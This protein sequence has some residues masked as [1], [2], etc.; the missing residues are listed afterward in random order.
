[1][2]IKA[3]VSKAE[4]KQAY[5]KAAKKH[6]PDTITGSDEMFKKLSEAYT[7]LKALPVNF[8]ENP[9]DPVFNWKN[10]QNPGFVRPSKKDPDFSKSYS[11]SDSGSVPQ[12]MYFFEGFVYALGVFLIASVGYLQLT[13]DS[14]LKEFFEARRQLSVAVE[15]KSLAAADYRMGRLIKY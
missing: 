6:H 14:S 1:M 3:G 15:E 4:L 9:R 7:K 10:F 12:R 11:Q 2:D 13:G 8:T 5:M